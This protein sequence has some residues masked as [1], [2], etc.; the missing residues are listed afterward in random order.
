LVKKVLGGKVAKSLNKGMHPEICNFIF[1][2]RIVDLVNESFSC[3]RGVALDTISFVLAKLLKTIERG[4][5]VATGTDNLFY[6]VLILW[7]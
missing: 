5:S 2:C 7:L 4:N 6:I 1:L 3:N